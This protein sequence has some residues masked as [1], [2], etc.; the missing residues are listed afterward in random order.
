[1]LRLD[2]GQRSA[3]GHIFGELANLVAAALV[4]GQFLGEQPFAWWT[5]TAGMGSW[6]V[7][8]SLAVLLAAGE[9][10]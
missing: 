10:P 9:R 3:L 1:M 5:L 7:L 6:G 4:L 2:R 8:V